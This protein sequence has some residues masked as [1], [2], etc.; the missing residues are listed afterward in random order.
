MSQ[1]T[2]L[3]RV[4]HLEST[5]YINLYIDKK[6]KKRRKQKSGNGQE[7][8]HKENWE[9]NNHEERRPPCTCKEKSK[10]RVNPTHINPM[11][12]HFKIYGTWC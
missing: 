7:A 4:P 5:K 11:E 6:M 2:Q 12:N 8:H 10:Q 1:Y 3:P 9:A